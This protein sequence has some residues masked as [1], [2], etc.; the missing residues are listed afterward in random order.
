MNI[1][2]PVLLFIMT[3]SINNMSGQTFN[4]E[5]GYSIILPDNWSE[6]ELEDEKNTNGFFDTSGWTGNLRVTPLN[7]KTENP[8]EFIRRQLTD[9][10]TNEQN[11]D[12]IKAFSYSEAS[13]DLWIYYWY[14]IEISKVYICSFTIDIDNKETEK[15]QRELL[16]VEAIL[17]TLKTK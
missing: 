6:Y 9:K 17:K 2:R 4:S 7:I 8:I 1:F 10:N 11:W 12:K 15:N 3:L 13:E 16:K 5:F 14:L